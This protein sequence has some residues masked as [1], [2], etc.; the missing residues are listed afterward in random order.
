[1]SSEI[2]QT[3]F[4]RVFD[5]LAEIRKRL[6][7]IEL[8][9][10]IVEDA[11]EWNSPEEIEDRIREY[12]FVKLSDRLQEIENRVNLPLKTRADLLYEYLVENEIGPADRLLTADVKRIFNNKNASQM[13]RVMKECA[14]IYKGRVI[15]NEYKNT[16]KIHLTD[17]EKMNIQVRNSKHVCSFL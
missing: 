4:E 15:A 13:I 8:A 1:M 10:G 3:D 14:E 12:G 6:T 2:P 11:H 9:C 5:E 7:A 16:Y 17:S